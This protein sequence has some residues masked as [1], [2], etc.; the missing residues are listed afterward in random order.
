MRRLICLNVALLLSTL[1]FGTAAANRDA[2]SI[3][4]IVR[5]T[6]NAVYESRLDIPYMKFDPA[7]ENAAAV[8]PPYAPA[9][10]DT[11]IEVKHG[12]GKKTYRV[13]RSGNLW[14]E[15]AARRFVLSADMAAKLKSDAESLR[16][17]HYGQM[18]D[19]ENARDLLPLKSVFSIKDVET[20][21]I[22]RVQRRAGS[23]HADVQPLT[24]ED[25]EVMKQI[26][27]GR[28]SWQRRA[29][30]AGDDNRWIAASMNGMPHGGD[31]IPDNG[32]SGHFCVHF[33][34]SS[35]HKSE[36]PDPAHQ[37]MVHKAGGQLRA[38]FEDASPTLFAQ[39][40]IEAMNVGDAEAVR[41]SLE[42]IPS[43]N[44]AAMLRLAASLSAVRMLEGRETP[45]AEDGLVSMLELDTAMQLNNSKK[46][47]AA[48]RLLFTRQSAQTPWR[49]QD[50]QAL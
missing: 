42:G 19:W 13:D 15:A 40:L 27:N 4:V 17:K 32:F 30:L 47:R 29:I 38:Y 43:D 21:L 50:V 24:R 37:L 11:Y 6:P 12:T 26:F 14:D 5:A 48:F 41:L 8:N 33:L 36:T 31:G 9:L 34:N 46:R 2:A 10:T 25:T 44:S 3:E 20:G 45:P 23:D 49:V 35:T 39:R 1:L 7:A 16:S 28:W 18:I 22:F